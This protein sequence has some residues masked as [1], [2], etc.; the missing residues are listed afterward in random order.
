MSDLVGSPDIIMIWPKGQSLLVPEPPAGYSARSLPP[1]HDSW[2]IEIHRQAIPSFQ[3]ADL[4]EWLKRYRSF[5]LDEGI[6]VAIHDQ[7]GQAVAT[8]GSIAHSKGEMFPNGGQLAWV[9]TVPQHRKQGLGTWLG[10]LATSRLQREGFKR[11]FLS[12]GDDL[13]DAIRVYLRLGYVPCF[14]A[15]D[16]RKRWNSI[17]KEIGM[18]FEPDNWPSLKDYLQE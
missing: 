11:I 16:Q 5:A 9:A 3:V 6:L 7:S 17:C 18:D 1:E 10:A 13:T 15:S 12:T 4:K 2:W 8:A 14:Y